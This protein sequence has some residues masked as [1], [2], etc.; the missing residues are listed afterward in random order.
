[1]VKDPGILNG[2]TL[3]SLLIQGTR[4]LRVHEALQKTKAEHVH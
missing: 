4:V 1:M 2:R 3:L